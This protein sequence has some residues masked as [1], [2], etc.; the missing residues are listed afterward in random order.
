MRPELVRQRPDVR[1]GRLKVLRDEQQPGP[2]RI[3]AI[4]HLTNRGGLPPGA[5]HDDGTESLPVCF[6]PVGVKQEMEAAGCIRG[7][8]GPGS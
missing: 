1:R 4:G 7:R 6:I 8:G 2:G 3:T 5:L